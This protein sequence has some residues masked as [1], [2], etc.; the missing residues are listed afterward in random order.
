MAKRHPVLVCT[1]GPPSDPTTPD[2]R[3]PRPTWT[4]KSLLCHEADW[5]GLCDLHKYMTA[6]PHPYSAF[7]FVWTQDQGSGDEPNCTNLA[8]VCVVRLNC[9]LH[10]VPLRGVFV[11]TVRETT[12]SS[13]YKAVVATPVVCLCISCF[14]RLK[15]YC[16]SSRATHLSLLSSSEK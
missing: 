10:S 4:M 9:A 14:P 6:H 13:K 16:R 15:Y 1:N 5:R 2:E 11:L 8:E 3:T 7:W 12:S